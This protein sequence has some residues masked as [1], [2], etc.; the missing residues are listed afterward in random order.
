MSSARIQA[1]KTEAAGPFR[2]RAISYPPDLRQPPHRHDTTSVTILLGGAI[3]ETARGREETGS[4]L[5]VVTKPAGV[6][7]ADVV[8]PA[9]ARTVQI[10]FGGDGPAVFEEAGDALDR[11]SWRQADPAVRPLVTVAHAV[12]QRTPPPAALED[13]VLEGLAALG[14]D[15][16]G[17]SGAPG[18]LSRVKEALDNDP[19]SGRTV[20][21]LARLAGAHPVSVSR[22]FRREY[23]LTITEYRRRRR[24]HRAATLAAEGR[25]SLSRVAHA[26]GYADHPHMC[27]D[28][29]RLVG[30]SPSAFRRLAGEG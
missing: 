27:R 20:D 12:L 19:F 2:V 1:E 5:S 7:H 18:W 3:R 22:A 21:D 26:A 9:G 25:E 8:G 29:R 11:W 15:P 17:G 14:R 13:L 23:G 28:F 30:L 16:V 24:L 10:A 4:A 6:R